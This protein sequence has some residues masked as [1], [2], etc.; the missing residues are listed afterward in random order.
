MESL[1]LVQA[2]PS[3]CGDEEGRAREKSEEVTDTQI[4]ERSRKKFEENS[5]F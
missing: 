2:H 5:F 1:L 3:S 4:I